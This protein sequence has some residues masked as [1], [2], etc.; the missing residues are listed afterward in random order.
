MPELCIIDDAL[1]Q[2]AKARQG[3]CDNRQTMQRKER[4]REHL[5]EPELFALFCEEYTR[6]MNA[7][8]IEATSAHASYRAELT[9]VTR[10]IVRLATIWDVTPRPQVAS[11]FSRL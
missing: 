4:L 7:L 11:R 5:M 10:D 9:K 2:A 8:R 3:T 1:W 6:H